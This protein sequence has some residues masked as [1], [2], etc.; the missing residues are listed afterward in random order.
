MLRYEPPA[1]ERVTLYCTWR[2]SALTT[3]PHG[4][5]VSYVSHWQDCH[6][7]LTALLYRL[8]LSNTLIE[9]VSYNTAVLLTPVC[10]QYC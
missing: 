8:T 9:T 7:L 10:C 4:R 5:S 6:C 3:G 1:T 2:P